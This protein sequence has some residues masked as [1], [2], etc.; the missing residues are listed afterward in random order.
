MLTSLSYSVDKI[1]EIN[2]ELEKSEKKIV[3]NLRSI[4]S[5]LSY[6]VDNLYMINKKI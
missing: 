6:K 4:S 2:K 3:E 5:S 1:S